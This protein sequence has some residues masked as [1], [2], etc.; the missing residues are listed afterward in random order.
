MSITSLPLVSRAAD[1]A[2]G[3]SI[4]PVVLALSVALPIALAMS[5]PRAWTVWQTGTFFDTDDAMRA[6][7]LRDWMAGQGWFDLT[8]HR[9]N[10]PDGI[11]M[12]WSRVVD[13]VL[14][15]LVRGFELV[16]PLDPAERAARIVFPIALQAALIA[17]MASTARILAG[18][19]AAVPAALLIVLGGISYGQFVPGRI[20]HHAPQILLLVLMTGAALASLDPARGARPRPSSAS[21]WPFRW[22]SASKTCPSWWRSWPRLPLAWAIV[23]ERMR[24]SLLWLALGLTVAGP[25]A[26]VATV[27]PSRYAIVSPD[28][29]SILHLAALGLGAAELL[30]LSLATRF[31]PGA[32]R[33][34]AV[35]AV[36]GSLV[37]M[38]LLALFPTGL[39]GPYDGVDA[40][41]QSLWLDHVT[42]AQ[43]LLEAV[44]E[45]PDTFSL[46]TAP[47]LAGGVAAIV[48][49]WT[50]RGL[51]R[52]RWALVVSL[53]VIG[54]AGACWEVRIVS[55]LQPLAL[56]GGAWAVA[57]V[58]TIA[59]ERSSPSYWALTTCLLLLFSSVGW[60]F[61]PMPAMSSERAAELAGGQACRDAGALAPLAELPVGLAFAPVDLGSHLLAETKLSVVAAPY[62][63]DIRGNRAVLQGFLAPPDEAHRLIVAA[64][65]H[66]VILCPGSVQTSVMTKA[67]PAGL[68]AALVA[69]RV[70]DWLT[71][72]PLTP[73]PYRVFAVE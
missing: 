45:R 52:A 10:P 40:L 17:A 54:F 60:A 24:A 41:V 18:P 14:A 70:P 13:V 26:F 48:A 67:A 66:Y 46:V 4:H 38:A 39:H 35:L 47:L 44:R 1:H 49:L 71:P 50:T 56:L 53:V 63:R 29:F 64:A 8:A 20:D 32:T 43:P 73:T 9:L 19:A 23:G 6:V 21:A 58:V 34:W 25:A 62:H 33:R 15:V 7:Q 68:A 30:T 42:E 12:H 27:A 11:F 5:W 2:P 51:A 72:V 22:R 65:A 69:G 28:A 36:T 31:C 55:S 57:R 37:A 59:R 16:L 61:V 3:R